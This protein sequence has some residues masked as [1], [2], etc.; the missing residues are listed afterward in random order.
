MD[1]EQPSSGLNV[2]TL[3]TYH[4]LKGTES[5]SEGTL[6]LMMLRENHGYQALRA[7]LVEMETDVAHPRQFLFRSV[8]MITTVI[9]SVGL[10]QQIVLDAE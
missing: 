7:R 6:Q 3:P 5:S 1:F 8:L 2:S 9:Q 4:N 10:P